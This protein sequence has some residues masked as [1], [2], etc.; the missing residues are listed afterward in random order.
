MAALFYQVFGTDDA[1]IRL[2]GQ[3]F[4]NIHRAYA[5]SDDDEALN[6]GVARHAADPV[7]LERIDREFQT[8]GSLAVPVATL[9]TTLDPDVPQFHQ[10]L[11]AAKVAAADA[12]SLL[13]QVTITQYGHCTFT[14]DELIAALASIADN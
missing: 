11:Y 1:R 9:H 4:D 5:G 2:G 7:A 13:R 8:S 6:L 14:A 3:P 10:P 12:T